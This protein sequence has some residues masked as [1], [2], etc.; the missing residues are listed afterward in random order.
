MNFEESMARLNE[1]VGLLENDKLPLDKALD[2][3]KEGMD[4]SV[5]CRKTLENAKL[6]VKT[7]NGADEND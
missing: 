3:Y 7:M 5:E 6:T 2:Y 4:L 1:L